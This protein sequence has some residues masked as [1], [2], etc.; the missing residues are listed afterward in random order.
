M[1]RVGH[2]AQQALVEIEDACQRTL[3][4]RLT[5]GGQ[6]G[7]RH[8]VDRVDRRRFVELLGDA[9]GEAI[10][11]V[12][13]PFRAVARCQV[14]LAPAGCSPS[15]NSLSLSGSPKFTQTWPKRCLSAPMTLKMSKIDSFFFCA[16]RNSPR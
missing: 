6:H 3:V 4:Q 5:A 16:P 11:G 1:G 14:L 10:G 12:A 9:L 13:E 15:R 7:Q 2:G 8:Q